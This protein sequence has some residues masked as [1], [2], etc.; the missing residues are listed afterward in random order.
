[1]S[2]LSFLCS[3]HPLGQVGPGRCRVSGVFL[4]VPLFPFPV[5][6]AMATEEFLL[7]EGPEVCSKC[8]LV[9]DFSCPHCQEKYCGEALCQY[10]NMLHECLCTCGNNMKLLQAIRQYEST[11][12][13]RR[14]QER[15]AEKRARP[16][17]IRQFV[18]RQH[19]S[20][21]SIHVY[22]FL[23]WNVRSGL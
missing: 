6:I 1:M 20:H 17:G 5:R 15:S 14:V 7:V 13:G 3:L 11:Y 16:Q 22:I 8:K 4:W 18:K 21:Y 19:R 23:A 9:L 10:P 2:S 12:V